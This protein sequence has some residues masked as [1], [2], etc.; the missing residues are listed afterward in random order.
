MIAKRFLAG[1][2]IFA[3]LVGPAL[4]Q[5]PARHLPPVTTVPPGAAALQGVRAP[6]PGAAPAAAPSAASSTA[7]V[8]LNTA[9]AS[10]LDTLPQV[11]KAR[12]AA[13]IAERSKRPFRDWADFSAR[14]HGTS[15]N[16]GVEAK[17]R[18]RVTF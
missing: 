10:Q 1:A 9:S 16:A 14:M 18:D 6:A 12:A 4:S 2:G 11:G 13:I 15:V 8:N 3:M 7:R 17:I 5:T